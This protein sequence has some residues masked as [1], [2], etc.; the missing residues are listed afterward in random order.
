MGARGDRAEVLDRTGALVGPGGRVEANP[1][2][3]SSLLDGG[4]LVPMVFVSSSTRV[5]W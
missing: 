4:A 5:P 3:I 2:T 1:A